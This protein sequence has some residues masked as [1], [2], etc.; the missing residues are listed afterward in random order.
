MCEMCGSSSKQVAW[1]LVDENAEI[2][3]CS[4][5]ARDLKRV[6]SVEKIKVS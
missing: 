6:A 2:E 1:Y 3:L 4:S 5:C